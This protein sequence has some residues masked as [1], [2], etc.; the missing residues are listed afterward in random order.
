MED[1]LKALE[2]LVFNQQTRIQFLENQNTLFNTDINTFL[3]EQINIAQGQRGTRGTDMITLMKYVTTT[4][5]TAVTKLQ[6]SVTDI[7]D[8]YIQN[9]HQSI[10]SLPLQHQQHQQHQPQ[11]IHELEEIKEG[12]KILEKQIVVEIT[13]LQNT[14]P[15]DYSPLT[16]LQTIVD[17]IIRDVNGLKK[18]DSKAFLDST[19]ST[20]SSNLRK[21]FIEQTALRATKESVVRC[22]DDIKRLEGLVMGLQTFLYKTSQPTTTIDTTEIQTV[23]KAYE[24]SSK[25]TFYAWFEQQKQTMDEYTKRKDK[26]LQHSMNISIQTIEKV[27]RTLPETILDNYITKYTAL[28]NELYSTIQSNETLN[29]EIITEINNKL[30]SEARQLSELQLS[31]VRL[32]KYVEDN[33]IRIIQQQ[34]SQYQPQLQPKEPT[35]S[36]HSRSK[37][38]SNVYTTLTKCFYTALFGPN[39]DTLGIFEPI[40]GWDYICF[41]D[42]DIESPVWKCIKVE[43]NFTNPVLDA[44]YVKWMSHDFVEDYD[45][46]IWLDAYISP[47][48]LQ[49]KLF[50]SWVMDMYNNN[51]QIGHRR[52]GERN[53]IWDECD[54]VIKSKRDTKEHVELVRN[55]LKKASMP[56]GWGLFDT[57]I[58]IKFHKDNYVKDISQKIFGILEQDSYRDQLT[59]PYIYYLNNYTSY[60]EYSLLEACLKTGIHIRISPD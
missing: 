46:V 34:Q 37:D 51:I 39:T 1:R 15:T 45:V 32:Q 40:P 60:K 58:V 42:S 28:R 35:K 27:N 5:A 2:L 24:D 49:D 30:T 54:A 4:I 22:S 26:E 29:T 11:N 12:M 41:T 18:I 52:H 14:K 33:P 36:K 10:I 19:L 25:E 8:V 55:R 20:L 3:N 31:Q 13:K 43:R 16:K 7:L 50:E 23:Y 48:P 6:Q 9:N 38:V 59:I 44:K 17:Q 47:N 21:E 56:K 53:C 57:N